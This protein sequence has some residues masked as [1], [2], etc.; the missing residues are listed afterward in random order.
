[1]KVKVGSYKRKIHFECI[2]VIKLLN[3]IDK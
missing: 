1:M 2:E 3:Q